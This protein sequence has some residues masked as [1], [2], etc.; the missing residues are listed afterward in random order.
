M[1]NLIKMT[2]YILSPAS[3]SR[4]R[5]IGNLLFSFQ[6]DLEV[7]V[8]HS[9]SDFNRQDGILIT[10]GKDYTEE[11]DI[12][13]PAEGILFENHLREELPEFEAFEDIQEIFIETHGANK[14]A[15]S[16]Q[17]D[18][19]SLCFVLVT[20]YEEYLPHET[21]D[22]DRYISTQSISV[23]NKW[24]QRPLVD[25]FILLFRMIIEKSSGLPVKWM[26]TYQNIPTIDI[27]I[28]F[29]Y[30]G[31]GL[32]NLLILGK[33]ILFG[34]VPKISQRLSFLLGGNDPYDT[35]SFMHKIFSEREIQPIHFILVKK[36]GKF[37]ENHLVGHSSFHALVKMIGH[38]YE[39]GLHP[40]IFSNHAEE[41]MNEEKK[42]LEDLAGQEI[43]SSRQH[44]LRLK[45][46]ETF[47]ILRSLGIQ[48]DYSMSYPDQ[49]GFRAGISTPYRWYDL[50]KDK[51]TDLVIRPNCFMDASAKHYLA[52][53]VEETIESVR[54]VK[55]TVKEVDGNFQ[56]IWHNSSFST[57]YGWKCWEKVFE[58]LM[59]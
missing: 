16:F 13:I 27:D 10:Y 40:S 36:H 31:K 8:I 39:V 2:L 33:D 25:E 45:H 26:R 38:S 58:A 54:R 46:P 18:V 17:L 49:I 48:N 1:L 22:F 5:Y 14:K 57:A 6:F 51:A 21:D 34:N 24:I 29:A 43:Q 28:P 47:R 53:S 32:L 55:Q 59:E 20:R 15:F 30:R 23:K 9:I 35:Y 56:W 3:S 11:A 12:I 42:V 44:F 4:L 52:Y 41:I 19:L 7:K 37:D 50:L